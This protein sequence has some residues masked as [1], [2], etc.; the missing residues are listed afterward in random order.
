[1]S[2]RKPIQ[3]PPHPDE[4]AERLAFRFV[5]FCKL[6][7]T[8]VGSIIIGHEFGWHIGLAVALLTWAARD[9]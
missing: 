3:L 9:I 6:A 4:I 1:M 2:D 5:D 7:S 8:V